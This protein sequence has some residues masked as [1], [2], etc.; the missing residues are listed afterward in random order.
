[1]TDHHRRPYFILTGF[2]VIMLLTSVIAYE[3]GNQMWGLAWGVA[4]VAF[5]V[6]LAKLAFPRRVELK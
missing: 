4:F 5:F 1:M 2:F 3:S 6:T